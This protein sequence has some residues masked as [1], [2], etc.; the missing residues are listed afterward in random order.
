MANPT[1]DSYTGSSGAV[2]RGGRGGGVI[3]PP[4]PPPP[5]VTGPLNT[6]FTLTSPST[7]ADA[8]FTIGHVFT[9]GQVAGTAVQV[10]GVT[11]QV[12]P[13]NY[14]PDG[15]LKFAVIA[16]TANLTANVPLTVTL[17]VGTASTGTALTI[18]DLKT[19]MSGQT[20][21]IDCG[22]FGSVSWATTDF[23]T[24]FESWV[25]GHRM[26]S[27]VYRKQ[28]GADAHLVGWV[29]VRVYAGGAVEVLPWIENCYL[30]TAAPTN[31][32]ATYAFTLGATERFSGSIDLPHHCRTPLLFGTA[33]S[34]WLGTDPNVIP[35]HDADYLQSTG[36]VPAYFTKTP[37]S[38]STITALPTTFAPLQLGSFPASGIGGVGGNTYVGMLPQWDVLYLTNGNAATFRSVNFN[39][40]STGRYPIHY[41]E[42][43]TFATV[44]DRNK[45]PRLSNHATLDTSF[46]PTNSGT[47][48][49]SWSRDHQPC[50]GYLAYL[51]TGRRYHLD[52]LETSVVYDTWIGISSPN[53]Q[54]G[55]GLHP[56]EVSG[57]SRRAAWAWRNLALALSVA[58]NE[59]YATEYRAQLKNNVDHYW[60]KYVGIGGPDA[61]RGN[62]Q[63]FVQPSSSYQLNLNGYV[64]ASTATS[65]TVSG[66]SFH[67]GNAQDGQFVGAE[68]DSLSNGQRRTITAYSAS[69]NTFTVSPGF[70][71]P[72]TIGSGVQVFDGIWWGAPW[73]QDYVTAAMGWVLDLG[74]DF[75]ATTD[76]RMTQ[77]FHWTAK[78]IVGR[79]GFTGSTEYL[80]RDFAPYQ[81]AI[82][83]FPFPNQAAWT[84]GTGPWYSDWGQIY[85]ATFGGTSLSDAEPP[86]PY[87][88]N[89]PRVEGAIRNSGF[90]NPEGS[91]AAAIPA[92]AYAVKHSVAGAEAAYQR[93]T[94]AEN[95]ASYV[96]T[97]DTNPLWSVAPYA[98]PRY[99]RGVA[100]N[101]MVEIPGSQLSL[102]APVNRPTTVD[103]VGSTNTTGTNRM[104]AWN[105]MS[106]DTRRNVAYMTRNGGHGDYLGNEVVSIDMM[107]DSPA[108]V[109][110]LPASIGNV[111]N[112]S[113]QIPNGGD[114]RY[115]QYRDGKPCSVHSYNGN[116]FLERHNRALSM[117]GSM[118]PRGSGFENV[119]AYQVG[120]GWDAYVCETQSPPYGYALGGVNNGWTQTLGF[121]IC[122]DPRTENFYTVSG[123]WTYRFTPNVPGV[124]GGSWTN[125]TN[126]PWTPYAASYSV[127]VCD[128]KRNRL[129][130][131]LGTLPTNVFT[132]D[133]ATN[134]WSAGFNFPASADASELLASP[135][136]A[137]P[138]NPN[139]TGSCGGV[140]VP[141][142]DTIYVRTGA[143]GSTVYKINPATFAV[144]KMTATGAVPAGAQPFVDQQGI[145][146]RWLYAPKLRGILYFPRATSNAFY[147]RTH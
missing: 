43:N 8:P 60:S 138:F 100:I 11:A 56:S 49:P 125:I 111:I 114:R 84:N 89:G 29:E 96:T 51:L 26:S 22:A 108:W 21:S 14:W 83:P 3:A 27:W 142:T 107:S 78:S 146:N 85:D 33:L 5:V 135:A 47:A 95:W 67:Y 28:V 110:V 145:F 55:L 69:T 113:A 13:K 105:G 79:L 106:I 88:P 1:S 25:S 122:K 104:D 112:S 65:V 16:G 64:S 126:S 2:V 9:Q 92:I 109:E 73:L 129:V 121:S 117:G 81:M 136:L 118:A 98:L 102:L 124:L 71:S 90:G 72:P 93:L 134:V 6:R 42:D 34:H 31:K 53:R 36:M 82:C 87:A 99:A 70:T 144:T 52:T 20:C 97:L 18:A 68:L 123:S 39:A 44:G 77:L 141:A 46:L 10:T 91:S 130:L 137:S 86:P 17:S 12:T 139:R 58:P 120:V 15:S 119:E 59:T 147:L 54:Y 75:D 131:M 132:L 127:F 80:Y 48:P 62:P 133:L 41:R 94:T 37:D 116:Q 128:T 7:N 63:G 23:D 30:L 140:Y 143:A 115:A 24:P 57:S 45:W 74:C 76:L 19:A 38:A 40:Y 4:P 50:V 103:G 32:S 66:T 101:Q 35:R 61:P